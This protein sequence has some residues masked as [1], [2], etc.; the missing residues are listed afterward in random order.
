MT[1][2]STRRTFSHLRRLTLYFTFSMP[3]LVSAPQVLSDTSVFRCTSPDGAV[4]LSQ[5]PCANDAFEE[6]LLIED[7]RTGWDPSL[8]GSSGET[9]SKGKRRKSKSKSKEKGSARRVRREEQCWKKEQLLDE[10]SWK[11]RRGYKPAQ[12]IKLRHK[13]QAYEDYIRRFCD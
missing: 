12:G 10:V 5:R 4:E 1:K 8:T 3:L 13:R 2:T 11:L 7:R 9:G 6:Q